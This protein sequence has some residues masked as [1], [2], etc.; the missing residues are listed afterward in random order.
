VIDP[1]GARGTLLVDLPRREG[2]RP[3]F[4]VESEG[5]FGLRHRVVLDG[6]ATTL[7]LPFERE[8]EQAVTLWDAGLGD[9]LLLSWRSIDV[10]PTLRRL[11]GGPGTLETLRTALDAMPAAAPGREQLTRVVQGMAQARS[12]LDVFV[13]HWRGLAT[14]EAVLIRARAAV[15]DRTGTA[16][17]EAR[18]A[19]NQ[20]SVDVQQAGAR[21]DLAWEAWQ[22]AVQTV[23]ALAPR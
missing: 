11:P 15:D 16:K 20:A 4:A 18:R 6:G 22:R 3:T 14:A 12:L 1:Q 21:A 13:T 8:V 10:Q 19:L 2:T 5:D 17:E 7:R 23:L 9:P